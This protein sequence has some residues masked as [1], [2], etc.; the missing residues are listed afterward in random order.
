MQCVKC[1]LRKARFLATG[2]LS[3][4]WSLSRICDFLGNR[5]GEKYYIENDEVYRANK[6]PPFNPHKIT[7]REDD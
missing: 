5:F 3:E 2:L 4:G 6:L 7:G 1:E